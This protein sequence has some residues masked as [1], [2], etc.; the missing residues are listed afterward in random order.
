M[1]AIA[2]RSRS[3]PLRTSVIGAPYRDDSV[4][5][6]S[7]SVSER[8]RNRLGPEMIGLGS[9]EERQVRAIARGIFN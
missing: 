5:V 8:P 7:K 1:A 6:S 3:S 9:E 2:P 4:T